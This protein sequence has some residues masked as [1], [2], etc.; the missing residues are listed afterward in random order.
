MGNHTQR[1]INGWKTSNQEYLED[2]NEAGRHIQTTLFRPPYGRIKK[3]QINQFLRYHPDRKI[4][5][6]NIL[7]GDWVTELS[8]ENCYK[9]INRSIRDGD[10]I[11]LHESDKAWDRMSYCLPRLL[12]DFSGKGYTFSVIN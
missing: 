7:A 2:I 10:I 3:S 11:V 6:W 4:V 1:H 12:E 8:P 5:M 9:R